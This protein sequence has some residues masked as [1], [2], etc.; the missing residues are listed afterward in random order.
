MGALDQEWPD[1]DRRDAALLSVLQ[2]T[3]R[4]Q[5][6]STPTPSQIRSIVAA[7]HGLTCEQAAEV[8]HLS[9]FTVKSHL[10]DARAI[11][12]CKTTA[13]LVA[14]SIRRGLIH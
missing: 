1:P 7:S 9:H 11:L 6:R 5:A 10:R 13:H 14:E 8:L 4:S 2:D 12:G 3:Y